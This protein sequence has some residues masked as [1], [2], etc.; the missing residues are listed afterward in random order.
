[1]S[2]R[3]LTLYAWIAVSL[4][5]CSP[6]HEPAAGP[7]SI[8]QDTALEYG[9]YAS[10]WTDCWQ[11]F[12]A[13]RT[14]LLAAVRIWGYLPSGVTLTV[15]QGEG[16]SGSAL[17]T[18]TSLTGHAADRWEAALPHVPVTAGSKYTV[19]LTAASDL[20]WIVGTAPYDGGVN[21]VYG[22]SADFG[23]TT[24]VGEPQSSWWSGLPR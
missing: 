18:T 11:S 12:T 16:P 6:E 24:Y 1:M 3:T 14:G 9:G 5:A 17:V 7:A 21:N 23:I 8:D 10:G 19:R 13:G 4:A 22:A 15:Y 2:W 20:N